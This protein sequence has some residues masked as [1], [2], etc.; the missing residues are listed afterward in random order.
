[1]G[2]K[3]VPLL[4]PDYVEATIKSDR[5]YGHYERGNGSSIYSEHNL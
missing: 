2:L 3:T 1:M 5:D 4:A